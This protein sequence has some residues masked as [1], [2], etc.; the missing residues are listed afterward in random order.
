MSG[1]SNTPESSSENFGADIPE[2]KLIMIGAPKSG[3]TS[4][5][6]WLGQHPEIQLAE[7]KECKFFTDFGTRQ[8]Q[9]P[10]VKDFKK[11]MVTDPDV[12]EGLFKNDKKAS[13]GLD[14]ST[15]YLWCDASA[16]LIERYARDREVKLI[17]VL[18]DPVARAFSEYAH[19]IR[20]DHQR[21]SFAQSL[22]LEQQRVNDGW[23][24]LFYHVT[25]SQ[26]GRSLRHYRQIFRPDQLLILPF[27]ALRNETE[28]LARVERFVGL[29]PHTYDTSMVHNQSSTARSRALTSLINDAN[30]LKAVFGGLVPPA[31][32]D[33]VKRAN[34]KRLTMSADQ[35]KM[36]YELLKEDIEVAGEML[37]FDTDHWVRAY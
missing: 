22:D 23:H 7:E 17:C 9:G 4:L 26:Y 27:E 34:S 5:A 20:D 32:K 8:W 10:G 37:D 16:Q 31:L 29:E 19:T 35:E 25:R 12:Y 18:R 15:D 28:V 30:P 14:A 1:Q 36:V 33:W 13:W 24:P 21:L 6:E 11:T 3:T 2:K